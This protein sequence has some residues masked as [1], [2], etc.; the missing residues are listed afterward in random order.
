MKDTTK[1][2]IAANLTVLTEPEGFQ[3]YILGY[4]GS[5]NPRAV[6]DVIKDITGMKKS[7]K[8]KK[9]K[10]KKKDYSTFSFYLNNKKG[11]KKKKKKNKHWH[12]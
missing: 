7:K 3:K 10:N 6:Y 1:A 9:K 4:K 2:K 5:G 8:D 11:K 12:F